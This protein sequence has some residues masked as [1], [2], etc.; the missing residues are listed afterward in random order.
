MVIKFTCENFPLYNACKYPIR[1]GLKMVAQ[2]LFLKT[3]VYCCS[4]YV[5][6]SN[7][8]KQMLYTLCVQCSEAHALYPL[9]PVFWRKCC[10]PFASSVLTQML[11]TLAS[12]IRAVSSRTGFFTS[13]H[14]ILKLFS[15][16]MIL[17]FIPF[18]NTPSWR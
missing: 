15:L 16:S 4:Y 11:S 8:L 18:F 1:L 3:S 12:A 17:P 7:V 14:C 13:V 9:R 5:I 2:F 6:A 10:I